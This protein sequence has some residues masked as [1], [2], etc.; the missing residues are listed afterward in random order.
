MLKVIKYTKSIPKH[1]KI[2]LNVG[3][4]TFVRVNHK[5]AAMAPIAIKIFVINLP[6]LMFS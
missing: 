5:Q 4:S 2:Q 3:S 6:T 1:T